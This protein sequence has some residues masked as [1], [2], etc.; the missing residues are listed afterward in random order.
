[1]PKTEKVERLAENMAIF[2]FHLTQEEMAQIASLNQNKRYL[3]PGV[4]CE[5]AFGLHCPVYD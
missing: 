4:F 5:A 1:M 3:D 2:D